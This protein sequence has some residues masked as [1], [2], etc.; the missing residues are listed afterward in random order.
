MAKST[1]IA[2]LRGVN[3][4]RNRRLGMAALRELLEKLGYE[5]ARTHQQSG[6]IVLTT[7]KSPQRV[8]SE[9]ERGIAAE[10]GLETEVF[11]RT[12]AELARI[13]KAD[14]L[15]DAVDNPSRYQVTFLAGKPPARVARELAKADVAPEQVVVRGREIY[16]WHPNGFQRSK[17]AKLLSEKQLGMG[18]TARNWNTVTKL[19]ELADG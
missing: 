8:K 12:H 19:L 4:A 5:G 6:N 18:G 9:L 10:L 14:P 13:V 16:A 1:Q 17:L 7:T 11:V 3:L 2:L 15:G